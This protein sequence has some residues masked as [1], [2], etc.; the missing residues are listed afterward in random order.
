M[1]LLNQISNH[2]KNTEY[3]NKNVSELYMSVN[4]YEGERY[5]SFSSHRG[6]SLKINIPMSLSIFFN[7][8]NQFYPDSIVFCLE[9]Y[10]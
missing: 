3:F 2:R 9:S 5:L 1:T 8:S 10:F 6:P 4:I 7:I